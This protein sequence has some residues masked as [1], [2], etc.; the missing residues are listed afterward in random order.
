[1]TEQEEEESFEEKKIRVIEQLSETLNI[2]PV[3]A[4]ILVNNGYLSMDGLKTAGM[5]DISALEGMD[6]E[7]LASIEAALEAFVKSSEISAE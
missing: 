2:A 6:E 4:E 5:K 1:M 7:S 3:K